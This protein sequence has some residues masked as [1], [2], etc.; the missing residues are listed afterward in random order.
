MA[1]KLLEMTANVRKWLEMAGYGWTGVAISSHFQLVPVFSYPSPVACDLS[2]VT[3]HLSPVMDHV[4]CVSCPVS[5]V[6]CRVSCFMCQLWHVIGCMSPIIYPVMFH[7]SLVRCNQS[8]FTFNKSPVAN[9]LSAVN[10]LRYK[11]L[12]IILFG[13]PK[14]YISWVIKKIFSNTY[15][16]NLIYFTLHWLSETNIYETVFSILHFC[17]SADL[18]LIRKDSNLH[19]H[20]LCFEKI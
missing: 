11:A 16:I 19:F 13:R 6:I 15:Y 5:C 9:N 10:T 2:S 18:V 20:K 4:S 14:L 17:S 8:C 3:S 1:G 12:L 7:L